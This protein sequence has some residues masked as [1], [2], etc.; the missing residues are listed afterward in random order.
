M[1]TRHSWIPLV[2]LSSLASAWQSTTR[3]SSTAL[4]NDGDAASFAARFGSDGQY[5]V[6]LSAA[7]DLVS[8]DPN[9]NTVDVYLK[10]F[11]NGSTQRVSLSNSGQSPNQDCLQAYVSA[12]GRYVL[13]SSA[14]TNL[15]GADTNNA[16]DSFVYDSLSA[17]TIRIGRDG[18]GAQIAQGS[19]A[20]GISADGSRIVLESSDAS[21]VPNDTNGS[22]DIFVRHSST[23]VLE[24]VSVATNGL[25]GNGASS[26]ALISAN[27]RY[28]AFT[29]TATN[30]IANDTNT[31][32]DV[33]LRDLLLGTTVAISVSSNGTPNNGACTPCAITADGRFVA[34]SS[35]SNNL[36]LGDVSNHDIFLRDRLL[37]TTELVSLNSQGIYSNGDSF[38]ASLSDDGRFVAFASV[39]TNL[40]ALDNNSASDVFVH[41]RWTARTEA[42]SVSTA[43]ALGNLAS[44]AQY[45]PSLSP[46]GWSVAFDS[47]ATNLVSPNL[48][49]AA[50]V[51]L[52]QRGE[53][54]S[55]VDLCFP[56]VAGTQDCPCSN[57][58]TSVGRGCNNSW[59]TGGARL[60]STGHPSL[61]SD[62]L[63][64]H[65]SG[66]TPTGTAILLQ[67]TLSNPFG[68]TQG[69][70]V[71]CASGTLVRL[72][73]QAA[74]GGSVAFPD[75]P[76][77]SISGRS[78]ELGDNI[79]AGTRRW[80]SV[81]YRDPIVLG[82]CVPGVTYNTTQTHEVLWQP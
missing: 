63:L 19:L 34:F 54:S 21:L 12:A 28:V 46:D 4:G 74:V 72:Y 57:P 39:G 20:Q 73:V 79:A 76:G 15:V 77:T 9:A 48:N 67:G 6:Y 27:G 38:R 33:F 42:V 61:A 17:L 78:A 68:L 71:R 60:Q 13:Y 62:F 35:L 18:S 3:L 30:L 31:A 29:S 23:G 52:R 81:Y 44:A 59:S 16:I 2:L 45:A 55:G 80:Y 22:S 37:G 41:D 8:P 1:F 50:D 47:S 69:Q 25:P 5:L 82:G 43:G 53:P 66:Q 32:A 75:G 64:L 24:L 70:G 49:S 65:T 51:F 7:T 58:P 11:V 40:V 56:G 14:A 10:N 36:V 26:A